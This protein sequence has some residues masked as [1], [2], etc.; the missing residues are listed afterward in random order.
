MKNSMFSAILQSAAIALPCAALAQQ[1]DY[2]ITEPTQAC[3]RLE[4][5]HTSVEKAVHG[6]GLRLGCTAVPKGTDVRLVARKGEVAQVVF[7]GVEG[8]LRRWVLT[9]VLGPNGI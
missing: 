6:Y 5:V 7:C 1:I 2:R 4:M 3:E 9:S 8:C